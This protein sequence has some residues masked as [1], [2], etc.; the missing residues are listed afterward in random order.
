[1]PMDVRD[2]AEN[3]VPWEAGEPL[4]RLVF[5]E[6]VAPL[7]EAVHKVARDLKGSRAL[8]VAAEK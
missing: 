5:A 8:R 7:V 4:D 2:Y 6:N 1:M 3:R